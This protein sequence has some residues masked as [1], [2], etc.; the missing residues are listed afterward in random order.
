MMKTDPVNW[1]ALATG[2]VVPQLETDLARG[3]PADE[4]RRRIERF[5]RNEL[6]ARRGRHPLVKFLLQFHQPLLY[7]LLAATVVTLFLREWVDAGVIF[8]VVFVNAVI[9]YLQESRAEKALAALTKMVVTECTVRRDGRKVRLP[10][11]DLVPGDVV[12]LQSGDKVPADLRLVR[13]RNLQIDESALTGES[14]P[15]E[16]S[17]DPLA[18]ETSLADRTNLAFAGT[19]VTFG[20]GEGV[21]VLTGDRTE[22][23]RI[24]RLMSEADDLATPLTRKIAEFSRLLLY[25]IL[26]LALVTFV[27]G[28]WRGGAAVEMFLAAVALAVAAVPEGLPAAVTITLAIGVSRMARRRAIVRKLPA[29]E[30]LG[31]TTVICSDKTGT[32]TQNQM[33]V[34]EIFAG[35]TLYHVTGAG[36]EP[37]GEIHQA[38]QPVVV[39]ENAALIECLGAGL[40]CN[41]SQLVRTEEGRTGVQGDP[42][43]AALIV[44][45]QKGGLSGEELGRRRPRREVIP[46]ESEY[47]YMATLHEHEELAGRVIYLKGAVE[48]LLP[49]CTHALRPDG[50]PGALEAEAIRQRAEEL[51]A[52]G[53]RV[54]AFARREVPDHHSRLEHE[55]V[56]GE[57]TF[58]GLQGKLD[59]P[60]PEAIEAVKK[61]QAAGIQVKMITGDHVLTARAI[62][63]QIGLRG[64]GE[65]EGPAGE[66]VRALTGQELGRLSDGD[67]SAVIDDTV[68]FARVAPEQKLRLVKALQA[69]GHF[70]AMTGDGVNDAPALRQANIGVAMGITGTE[71]AK[72]S[73]DIVLTD[74][75]FATIQ[76]AV[77]EGRGIFDNLTKFIIWTI[78]TN[79]GQGLI[80]MTAIF[81]G[82]TL[83]LLPVQLLWVNMTTAILLGLMLVFEPK[84]A[85]LMQRPPRDPAKPILTFPLFM[86]SG[87]VT[88]LL[89]GGAFG[90][91]LWSL[92]NPEQTIESTRTAVVNTIV[93]VQSFYLLN[94]RALTQSAF[95]NGLF[96]NRWVWFGIGTML[97]AQLVFTYAPFMN[98]LFHTA[99]IPA[100]EWLTITG[101]GL[102]V[103]GIVEFEKWVRRRTHRGEEA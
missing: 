72:E 83:P 96:T 76:A 23:G 17:T 100:V 75:N 69:R 19:L 99:P 18:S 101:I 4:A 31:S 93:M 55:D 102:V 52:R 37:E 53:L 2:A 5:G 42:T 79:A 34:Q 46:F 98:T 47:Q 44:A 59:P 20:Q 88:L 70:V 51:A 80:I 68:V 6:T 62:A 22:T 30:T 82:F 40:L 3:L 14:L 86:R 12:L 57:L 92:K 32:L 36:Y 77:E 43:E 84:E 29:V 87:L 8:G 56:A 94:C 54:L 60:R 63:Q 45:A 66:A 64:A 97:S 90:M 61:C 73:A 24:A 7:I 67:L 10:A 39:G 33:T 35:D 15:V 85:N 89:L 50:S 25:A 9:G 26:A 27:F 71:V 21:V 78:P 16:K 65:E 28:V 1:H 13:L 58:L 103:F 81:A 95:S 48:K 11:G 49:R 74:D 38:G 91:F 41:D